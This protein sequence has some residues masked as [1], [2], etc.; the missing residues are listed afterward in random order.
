[1]NVRINVT[2]KSAKANMWNIIKPNNDGEN[3]SLGL[4]NIIKEKLVHAIKITLPYKYRFSFWIDLKRLRSKAKKPRGR[5]IPN[6][7]KNKT[8]SVSPNTVNS[9]VKNVIRIII[10]IKRATLFA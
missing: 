3:N 9:S 8:L 1:M 6:F 4:C 2:R 7:T 10:E 5:V